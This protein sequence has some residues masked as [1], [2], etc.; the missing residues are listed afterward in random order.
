MIINFYIK[1]QLHDFLCENF[2]VLVQLQEIL[3]AE[4][5]CTK[6]K[7]YYLPVIYKNF[8]TRP[9]KPEVTLITDQGLPWMIDGCN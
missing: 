2:L 8:L 5:V 4:R 1:I 3:I 7:M 6:P 9:W